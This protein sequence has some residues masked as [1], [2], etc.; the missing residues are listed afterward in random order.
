MA[1]NCERARRRGSVGR[2]LPG[3]RVVVDHAVGERQGQ[4]EIIAY[5][6]NVMRGYHGRPLETREALL[7]DGG[8][9]TGD[10]GYLDTDGFLFITGRLKEQYKFENGKYVLPS[11]VE[12]QLKLS[13]LVA[14]AVVYGDGKPFNVALVVPDRTELEDWARREGI[15]L[16][17]VERDPS[18]RALIRDELAERSL[19]LRSFEKPRNFIL[20]SREFTVENGLLTPSLKVR[21][22]R[23]LEQ[24]GSQLDALYTG[25]R[26]QP[27]T[28]TPLPR[29]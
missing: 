28:A 20:V 8:L 1:A 21:R 11:E 10:L 26:Y 22:D 18:V 17:D 16:G 15:D 4:G 7:P 12:E 6:D 27:P 5:G 19:A 23:V 9:R 24:Y 29:C 13:P 14:Q 2:P 25:A 3:V